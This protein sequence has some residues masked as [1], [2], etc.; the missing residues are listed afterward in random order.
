MSELLALTLWIPINKWTLATGL[1]LAG[2]ACMRQLGD[3]IID[4]FVTCA[5]VGLW[6]G[7]LIGAFL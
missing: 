4:S 3:W 2:L 1:T 6:V 5:L 7:V